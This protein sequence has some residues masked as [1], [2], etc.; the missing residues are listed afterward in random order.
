MVHTNGTKK[1]TQD[2]FLV[3]YK[4]VQSTGF[5][6]TYFGRSIFEMFYLLY[7]K[8]FETTSIDLLKTFVKPGA[9]VI[10]VGANIGFFTLNFANWVSKGGKVLAFEPE[11][12]N[13]ERL[14]KN[15]RRNKVSESVKAYNM[16]VS[17][18]F[19]EALLEI[20]PLHPG[21]HKLGEE[22]IPVKVTSI[23]YFLNEHKWTEV[24][25]IKIDVQGAEAKVISGAV[26][27]LKKYKPALFIEVDDSNL[28]NYGSSAKALLQFCELFGYVV[29]LLE[30]GTISPPICLDSAVSIAL[31][32]GYKDFLLL[33]S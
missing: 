13:Y 22:G 3:F 7:K 11:K 24:S 4:L 23:D 33:P 9:F 26:K 21:D 19:G 16:A 15:I 18:G 10:D 2:I 30:K 28:Q 32:S 14:K 8:R 12:I 6:N 27:T 17:E 29:H 31:E 1:T 25:L 5:L 20:N